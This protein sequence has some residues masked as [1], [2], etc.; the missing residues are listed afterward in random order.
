MFDRFCSIKSPTRHCA[1]RA[2]AAKS[3]L[4]GRLAVANAQTMF[5][6]VCPLNSFK[7]CSAEP[8][9]AMISLSPCGFVANAHAVFA[10][11]YACSEFTSCFAASAKALKS[12]L[13]WFST[14]AYAH[15][16]L[17]RAY[18][19]KSEIRHSTALA[20]ALNSS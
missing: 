12:F 8:A 11:S 3:C 17:D 18:P 13:S 16:V 1:I 6:R 5:A 10:S 19:L 15:A 2:K 9:M 14:V 20:R 4:C 7:H